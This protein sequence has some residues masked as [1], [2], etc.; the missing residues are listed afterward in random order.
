MVM[1]FHDDSGDAV[2]ELIGTVVAPSV[3]L[4]L[5]VQRIENNIPEQQ[6]DSPT[7]PKYITNMSTTYG[8]SA[9]VSAQYGS[10][11]TNGDV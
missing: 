9:W 7:A 4:V 5:R 6:N 1:H 3:D 2:L 8:N 10:A 11:S